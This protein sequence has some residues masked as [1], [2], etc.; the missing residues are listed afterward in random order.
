MRL[1]PSE[2]LVYGDSPWATCHI[3]AVGANLRWHNEAERSQVRPGVREKGKG[4]GARSSE[5]RTLVRPLPADKY[6][7]A[8]HRLWMRRTSSKPCEGS[9]A[10]TRESTVVVAGM[11]RCKAR[12]RRFPPSHST[13]PGPLPRRSMKTQGWWSPIS[14]GRGPCPTGRRQPAPVGCVTGTVT[15]PGDPTREL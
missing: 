7:P 10:N 13:L 1:F 14:R 2:R 5:V 15:A 8:I 6:D 12:F 3:V 9:T 4:R 11:T